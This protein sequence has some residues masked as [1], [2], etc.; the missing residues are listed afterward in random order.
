[1]LFLISFVR[2]ENDRPF[3]IVPLVKQRQKK[4]EFLKLLFKANSRTNFDENSLSLPIYIL[5]R[6]IHLRRDTMQRDRWR[7]ER[8]IGSF[9]FISFNKLSNKILSIIYY[10][11]IYY[12]YY[13]FRTGILYLLTWIFRERINICQWLHNRFN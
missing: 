11:F 9:L 2:C 13:W 7:I 4:E 8:P 3:H 1:M 12:I 5:S 10:I 6:E